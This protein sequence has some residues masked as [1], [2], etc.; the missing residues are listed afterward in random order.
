MGHY[1]FQHSTPP[2]PTTLIGL[3]CKDYRQG[4]PSGVFVVLAVAWFVMFG[5]AWIAGMWPE[6]TTTDHATHPNEEIVQQ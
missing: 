5:G 1:K 3:D 2:D 4:R 6:A